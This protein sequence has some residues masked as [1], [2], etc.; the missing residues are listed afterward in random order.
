[1]KILLSLLGSCFGRRPREDQ[2]EQQAS[3]QRHRRGRPWPFWWARVLESPGHESMWQLDP[4][5]QHTWEQKGH[6]SRNAD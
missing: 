5:P 4:L 1:M 3:N 2:N 6:L